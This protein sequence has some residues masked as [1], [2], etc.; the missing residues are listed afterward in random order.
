MNKRR[1]A[2]LT[3]ALRLAE[4]TGYLRVT[5]DDIAIAAG[6]SPALV[7]HYLGTMPQT[8]RY[9]MGEA[10]RMKCLSV[11]AQGLAHGDRRALNAPLAVREA[12]AASLVKQ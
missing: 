8:R 3:A 5:R 4:T 2:M 1:Q 12:A 6:C 11:I 7:S 9:I 10:L